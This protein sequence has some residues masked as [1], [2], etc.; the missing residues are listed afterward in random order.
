MKTN[1]QNL[2]NFFPKAVPLITVAA[3][4]M[5]NQSCQQAQDNGRHLK[6]TASVGSI[7]AQNITLPTGEVVDFP[8]VANTLFYNQVYINDYFIQV[9]P[10]SAVL[11]TVSNST[12]TS[13]PTTL[14]PAKSTT[15]TAAVAR[16]A[17]LLMSHGFGASKTSANIHAEDATSTAAQAAVPSCL[18]TSP[19]AQ[20]SGSVISFEVSGGG[21]LSIGYPSTGPVTEASGSISIQNSDLNMT[22]DSVEPFWGDVPKVSTN[23]VVTSSNSTFSIDLLSMIGLNFFFNTPIAT[24][25]ENGMQTGLNAIVAGYEGSSGTVAAWNAAWE[26]RVLYAPTIA[27]DTTQIAIGAGSNANVEV[28]DQFLITNMNYQWNGT[29]CTSTFQASTMPVPTLGQVVIQIIETGEYASVGTVVGEPNYPGAILPGAMVQL[30]AF[31]TPTPSPT[32]GAS[33]NPA[34]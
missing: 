19:Q 30:Q 18:Y 26:S 31:A 25:I 9:S 3:L 13:S 20:L 7:T 2:A 28:G 4:N 32:P 10:I 23:S 6:M 11:K 22:F 17:A 8:Y 24:T 34:Q 5:G 29:P 12:S 1:F 21:G 15:V 27:N 14:A 33:P 16:D